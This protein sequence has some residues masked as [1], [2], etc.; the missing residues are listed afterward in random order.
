AQSVGGAIGNAIAPANV[1]LGTSTAG[2]KGKDSEVF[3]YTIVFTIIS[4]ILV[5]ATAVLMF[6]MTG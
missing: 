1:I 4:G 3:K 6:L 5:S 2:I